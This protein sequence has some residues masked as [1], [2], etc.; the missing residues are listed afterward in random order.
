MSQDVAL[1]DESVYVLWRR[2][3][4]AGMPR[5]VFLAMLAQG[6]AALILAAC[7]QPASQAPAPDTTPSEVSP[8][9]AEQ[10]PIVKP[11]PE[12]QFIRHGTNA[13]MRF[14]MMANQKYVTPNANFFVRNHTETPQIDVQTWKLRIEGDGVESPY[15]LSYDELLTLPSTTHT[16]YVECAGNA[17]SF[18]DTLLQ[19]PAKGTQ[20]GLGAYGIAVWTG[21]SLAT[22][23]NQAG[24][25]P[26]AVDVMPTGLDS[27]GI[28]RPMSIE[29]AMDGQTLLAYQMNGETLPPDHGFPARAIVPGWV[30][31]GNIKWV[32]KI[33]V[34]TQP[35]FVT[36][37][38]TDYVLIGPDYP[39]QGEASGPILSEQNV[40]SAVA[41]PWPATLSAGEQTISGYAWAPGTITQVEV[42]LDGGASYQAAQLVGDNLPGAGTRWEFRFTAQPGELTISPRATDDSGN[43]QYDLAQQVW[44]EK[45]YLFGAVIPHP[46][47][48]TA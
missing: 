25:K 5:R 30:G 46:V 15:E 12:D 33:T 1:R 43:T 42:S 45:G 37:N 40:K 22:L 31:I 24:V 16:C 7:G 47:T 39:P 44:N 14:E 3:Q 29:K 11:I 35:L 23:L 10:P 36:K 26:E 20:W 27:L 28:E 41:L 6:G 34:S 13:E 21:A 32:G 19:K 9:Q 4:Q 2:A 17:R 48:V 18:F 8:N 38:T